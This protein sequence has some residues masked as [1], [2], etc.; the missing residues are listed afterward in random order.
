MSSELRV[1]L[2]TD[3]GTDVDDC[4]A[5][6][7]LLGSPELRLESVTCVYGDV[8]LRARMVRAL[9][10]LAGR[11]RVPVFAGASRPLLG[12]K[13]VYWEGHEG[14]GILDGDAGGLEPD[15]GHAVQHLIEAVLAAP[16]QIHLVAI[17]PLTNVALAFLLEP[18]LPQ[19]LARLTIMGGAVRGPSS[20]GLPY[21]EHN[22]ASD[23]EAAHVVLTSGAPVT[24]VPLDVTTRV[25]VDREG[26]VRIAAGG[27]PF[28]QAVAGQLTAY[29]RFARNGWTY[30]HDPLAVGTLLRPELVKLAPL[31]VEVELQGRLASGV[32]LARE[33]TGELGPNVDVAVDVAAHDFEQLFVERVST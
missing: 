18:R 33:P 24:L 17:G 7:L 29:P 2:D 28:H 9:L 26:A 3:I 19:M 30:L 27:T 31:H 5:L 1:I 25:R 23:P 10:R 8:Q 12:L 15:A 6:A 14:R 13:P 21:A 4:L 22:I 16:G 32:T 20:L 11:E